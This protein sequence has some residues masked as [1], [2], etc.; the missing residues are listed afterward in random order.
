MAR[1]PTRKTMELNL[2][3][4]AMFL[5]VTRA[6]RPGAESLLPPPKTGNT[7]DP[8]KL[9]EI[10]ATKTAK[11]LA[12][13]LHWPMT[14][15][16]QEIT[17]LDW[18][19]AVVGGWECKADDTS[20]ASVGFCSFLAQFPAIIPHLVAEPRTCAP[21]RWWGFDI[22]TSLSM[23]AMEAM[24]NN[25]EQDAAGQCPVPWHIWWSPGTTASVPF[26]DP[27]QTLI[28]SAARSAAGF[29]STEMAT[30]FG[31]EADP[32]H[33]ASHQQAEFARGFIRASGALAGLGV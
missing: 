23:I 27:F 11:A 26:L 18:S 17:L 8:V 24:R 2:T 29:T 12:E 32:G 30:Y 3:K 13:A 31:L 28:P 21:V 15:Y 7:T 6:A 33:S 10:R 4:N 20:A 25:R 9:K 14:G 16:V 1:Q 19:G 22:R 5:G